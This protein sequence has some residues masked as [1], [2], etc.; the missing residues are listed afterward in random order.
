MATDYFISYSMADKLALLRGI[1]ESLMSGQ[2]VRVS[3]SRGVETQFN[4]N[5]DNSLM[6]QRLCESVANDPN[7]DP[8]DPVQAG[9]LANR[10]VG[11]TRGQFNTR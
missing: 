11:I 8:T 4:P 7:F 10:R 6:Y 9:C 2:I 5:I 3:T 1:T